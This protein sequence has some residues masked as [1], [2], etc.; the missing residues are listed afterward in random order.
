[1]TSYETIYNRA[2]SKLEDYDL[3]QLPEE[4]LER[5]LNGWMMS[6]IAKFRKCQSDLKQRDEENKTFLI[7]LLD[8]EVEILAILTA[9]EWLESQINSI[10]LTKQ[11]FGGKEEKWFSQSQH[12][13]T[14]MAL[15]DS[16]RLEARK[17]MR[18]FTY[19]HNSYLA[20]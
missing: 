16:N 19:S 2:L 4:D 3:A 8:E 17:L 20:D 10:T 12:L 11:F 1:M 14:L 7:D 9:T 15:R 13:S 18:D 6:A 5:M